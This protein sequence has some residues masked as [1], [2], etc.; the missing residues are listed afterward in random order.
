MKNVMECNGYM[1]SVE[2]SADDDCFFGK[3]L[4]INDLVTFE[5]TSINE[6]KSAFRDALADYIQVCQRQ[7]KEPERPYKGSF[8]VRISPALHRQA[9]QYAAAQGLTLNR[10]VE[11]AIEDYVHHT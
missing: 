7:G 9:A 4:G 10:F 8:N 5:G 2:Y 11:Q 6:L 1:G 3:V